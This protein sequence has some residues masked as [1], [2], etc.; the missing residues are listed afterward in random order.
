MKE[1]KKIKAK[2]SSTKDDSSV[3]EKTS[4]QSA[5]NRF[6]QVVK[7]I[8]PGGKTT[9]KCNMK[10]SIKVFQLDTVVAPGS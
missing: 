8:M 6:K 5:F 3:S 4:K 2:D 1:A 7:K 9:K 10:V